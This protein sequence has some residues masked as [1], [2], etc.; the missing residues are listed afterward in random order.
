MESPEY[1]NFQ[2]HLSGKA[3]ERTKYGRKRSTS[4]MEGRAFERTVQKNIF[5]NMEEI[6]KKWS[7]HIKFVQQR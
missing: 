4:K 6:H 2:E 5:Y 3:S 1:N 7:K